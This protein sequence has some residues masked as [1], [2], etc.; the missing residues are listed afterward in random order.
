M[1]SE[2]KEAFIARRKAEQKKSFEELLT[3]PAVKLMLS[4][5]PATEPPELLKTLMEIFYDAGIAHGVGGVMTEVARSI[6]R[7]D[8]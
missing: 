5:V 6:V 4:M 1:T 7:G 3:G 8:K 2:T